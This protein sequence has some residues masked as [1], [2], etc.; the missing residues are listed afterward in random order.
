MTT[1]IARKHSFPFC[2]GGMELTDR[3]LCDA[4][5]EFERT[6]V[7]VSELFLWLLQNH[8]DRTIICAAVE[9][10]ATSFAL[11]V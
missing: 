11:F 5:E 6:M 1:S 7:D 4:L 9:S 8:L 3:E 10:G 2:L